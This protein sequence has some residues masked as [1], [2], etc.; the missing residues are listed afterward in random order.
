[1]W[2]S[3][4]LWEWLAFLDDLCADGLE[5]HFHLHADSG[6][7]DDHLSFPEA[8]CRGFTTPDHFTAPWDSF[9]ALSVI[10]QRFPRARKVFEV[11]P[12]QALGNQERVSELITRLRTH[13]APAD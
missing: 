13:E 8:E 1:V 6:L 10:D 7:A 5:L 9:E 3:E 2:S 12:Q 4:P 11:A